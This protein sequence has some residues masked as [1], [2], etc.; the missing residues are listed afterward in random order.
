MSSKSNIWNFDDLGEEKDLDISSKNE[1]SAAS[2]LLGKNVSK[3]TM[4][5]KR[6]LVRSRDDVRFSS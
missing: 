4:R 1:E 2:I 3:A 5:L 6:P